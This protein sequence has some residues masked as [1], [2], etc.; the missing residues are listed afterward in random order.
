MKRDLQNTFDCYC[1]CGQVYRSKMIEPTDPSV[2][3]E[4]KD[5][6]PGCGSSTSVGSHV[7]ASA[8]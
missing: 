5:K 1:R 7:F 3:V 2:R 6:C 4:S 8:G